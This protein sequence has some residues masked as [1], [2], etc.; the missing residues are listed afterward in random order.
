MSLK[1]KTDI[2]NKL[3]SLVTEILQE[4]TVSSNSYLDRIPFYRLASIEDD[5]RKN[6]DLWAKCEKY[7]SDRPLQD[8]FLRNYRQRT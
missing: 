7:I 1:F 4:A 5:L 2:R 3:A 6:K 8:F